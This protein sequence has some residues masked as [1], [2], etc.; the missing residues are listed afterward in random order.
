VEGDDRKVGNDELLTYYEYATS[1]NGW[2]LDRPKRL[3]RTDVNGNKVQESRF[4]Y[5]GKPYEGLPYGLVDQGDLIREEAWKSG[6][7]YIDKIRNACDSYGNIIGFKNGNGDLREVEY[8]PTFHTYPISETVHIGGG[9]TLTYSA[10]YDY[11]F[12]VMTSS[13]NFNDNTT[14]YAY[15]NFGLLESVVKPGDT[16]EYPTVTYLYTFGSPSS[17]ETRLREVSGGEGTFNQITYY[18]GLGRLIQTKEEGESSQ[19]IVRSSIIYNGRMLAKESYLPYFSEAN[20][21][22]WAYEQPNPLLHKQTFEYDPLGRTLQLTQPDD[23]FQRWQ[24]FPLQQLH[25]DEEDTQPGSSHHDTPKTYT[26]DGLN[27]LIQ[28]QE[29]NAGAMYTTTYQWSE[30]NT[31]KGIVDAEGNVKTMGYDGLGRK[32][33]MVSPD[34][35]KVDYMFDDSGNII[36]TIDA[37]LQTIRFTYDGANRLTS[38]NYLSTPTDTK[39]EIVYHYDEPSTIQS[40]S[41]KACA[42][43]AENVHGRLS[44]VEDLS[45]RE[46]RSY[47][48]HGNL[49]YRI[50][51]IDS[52]TYATE[53]TYD[54]MDRVSTITYPDDEV[55]TY[56]YNNRS[57][58][59]EISGV[60][61]EIEYTE[62]G[63]LKLLDYSNGVRSLYDYDA[64]LR[65]ENIATQKGLGTGEVIQDLNYTF[66][67]TSNILQIEDQREVSPERLATLATQNFIYDDL[68]RLIQASGYYGAAGEQGTINFAYDSIGNM[69][70]KTSSDVS[71]Q[72]LGTIEYGKNAGPH[73]LTSA[74][75]ISYTYDANGSLK[76]RGDLQFE[77]DYKDR[78]TRVT[79][80]DGSEVEFVYDYT[81]I[82]VKKIDQPVLEG[83]REAVTYYIDKYSEVRD[84][85]F[86]KYVYMGDQRIA[87][88]VDSPV[89]PRG[90]GLLASSVG[91]NSPILPFQQGVDLLLFMIPIFFI[92]FLRFRDEIVLAFETNRPKKFFS[93]LLIGIG[94]SSL[95]PVEVWAAI[96]CR[97]TERVVHF[98]HQDHLQSS[99]VVTDEEGNTMEEIAYYPYGQVRYREGTVGS[100]Y[101]FGGKEYIGGADLYY[102]GA[103]FYDPVVGRF[104]TT[105]RLYEEL[106][107]FSPEE[108]TPTLQNPQNLNTYSYTANNPVNYTDPT[109]YGWFDWIGDV[110]EAVG[111]LFSDVVETIVEAVTEIV[112]FIQEEIIEPILNLVEVVVQFVQE[113]VNPVVEFFSNFVEKVINP[114]VDAFK[115]FTQAV[116]ALFQ[117][118]F[119]GFLT[120]LGA[121]FVSLGTAFVNLGEGLSAVSKLAAFV[122]PQAVPYLDQAAVFF[123]TT[124]GKLQTTGARLQ[125]AAE[126]VAVIEEKIDSIF[127]SGGAK[128]CF[129][130]PCY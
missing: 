4:Y 37:K 5:D 6:T 44:W 12:G 39:A 9:K 46:F 7:E 59:D 107:E 86:T 3:L 100:D 40:V 28:V 122:F 55:F 73:A 8:D 54:A 50:K 70:S 71:S 80:P 101:T 81:G 68:N 109:G 89:I 79:P 53:F 43:P 88:V 76:S 105:D 64:R 106:S 124:G 113:V 119:S 51:E 18:D 34:H 108:L 112:D 75:G 82:A 111:D 45:G 118:D 72:N 83:G 26:Y 20:P 129:T 90:R 29:N 62:S 93:L 27:R 116:E 1:T 47:D 102:F 103:R 110:F 25:W 92:L 123:Q 63:Q 57:L 42:T 11:G 14:Q 23:S 77:Y 35:G 84:G 97:P 52:K 36:E 69:E 19:F 87:K 115:S 16:L 58:L 33:W 67:A 96:S 30:L 125:K 61:S 120:H 114:I 48:V 98:I 49:A 17:V 60:V 104:I 128:I 95:W 91:F 41:A 74:E 24:Y 38:E 2:P 126:T 66:D 15:N 31:L 78:L 65:I 85:V 10:T 22:T 13:T 94:L 99:S 32:V 130:Y 56:V 21:P 127:Q 117:A 121:A